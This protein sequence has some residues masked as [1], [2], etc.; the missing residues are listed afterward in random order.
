MEAYLPVIH[1]NNTWVWNILQ[2]FNNICTSFLLFFFVIFF[3]QFWPFCKQETLSGKIS[4]FLQGMF[5][6]E[7]DNIGHKS[8][9]IKCY[10]SIKEGSEK[11]YYVPNASFIPHCI[12]I[13]NKT[14]RPIPTEQSWR[15]EVQQEASLYDCLARLDACEQPCPALLTAS[16]LFPR[17]SPPSSSLAEYYG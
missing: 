4:V 14:H 13:G 1:N 12:L 8:N 7:L 11:I 5:H 3:L 17:T 10:R 15:Y 16:I 9:D 2:N 6:D